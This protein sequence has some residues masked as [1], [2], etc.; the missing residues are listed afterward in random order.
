MYYTA[1]G[2]LVNNTLTH[3]CY[4]VVA[5]LE[6]RRIEGQRIIL[7]LEEAKMLR[8]S[9]KKIKKEHMKLKV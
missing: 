5:Q 9:A 1:Y 2:R 8:E 6:M 3:C 4:V 7:D